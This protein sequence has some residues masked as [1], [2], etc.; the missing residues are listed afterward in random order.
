MYYSDLITKKPTLE[1]YWF[2]WY[3]RASEVWT[4]EHKKIIG[5]GLK[6]H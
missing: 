5:I 4:W 6:L 3:R 1:K 2:G